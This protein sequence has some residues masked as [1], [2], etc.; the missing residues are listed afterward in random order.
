M[1]GGGEGRSLRLRHQRRAARPS[2]PSVAIWIASGANGLRSAPTAARRGERQPDFGIGRARDR[3]EQIGRDHRRPRARPPR[4]SRRTACS[5]RTTPLTCGGQA[6]VTISD[7]HQRGCQARRG[8][9]ERRGQRVARRDLLRPVEDLHPPVE[10]LDQ[11]GAAF[12]PVAVIIISRR[13]RTRGSRR[14]GYGRTPRRRP[15]SRAASCATDLLEAR[16]ELDRVLDLVLGDAWTATNRAGPA[17]G[18]PRSPPALSRIRQFVGPR[19]RRRRASGA[20]A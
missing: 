1:I 4:S 13:R 2:G 17:G 12:D 14:C 5:V 8:I 3:A 9:R 10:M 6:S 18:G 15:C 16:D 11:R 20:P 19:R 7:A